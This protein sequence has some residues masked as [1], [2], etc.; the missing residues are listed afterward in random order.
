MKDKKKKEFN[1]MLEVEEFK[2]T[3]TD[4][5]LEQLE[6][7][8]QKLIKEADE[9][10]EARQKM[11]FKLPSK[12]YVEAMTAIR[13]ALNTMSVQWQYALGLKAMYEFFDPENRRTEVEFTMLDS[14]LRTLGNAQLKGYDQWNAVVVISDY[15]ESIRDE[16]AVASAEVY[17]DAEKHNAVVNQMQLHTAAPKETASQG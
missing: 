9:H 6:E 7:L 1:P 16:Y 13:M 2:K 3:L 8:E 10:N 12:N 4:M 15:F 14:M 17:V 11:T 5:T